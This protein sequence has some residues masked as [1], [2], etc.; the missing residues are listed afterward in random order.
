MPLVVLFFPSIWVSSRLAG[1]AIYAARGLRSGGGG[2]A[3]ITTV[4]FTTAVAGNF[5]RK[6]RC[7]NWISSRWLQ[8]FGGGSRVQ[9]K[10]ASMR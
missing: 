4:V 1:L 3:E 5:V 9:K 6:M 7:G 10:S 8:M 2:T